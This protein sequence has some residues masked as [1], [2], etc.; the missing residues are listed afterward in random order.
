MHD[1]GGRPFSFL[2][3]IHLKNMVGGELWFPDALQGA[4]W[5][6]KMANRLL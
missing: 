1:D 6:Y 3:F 2:Q 4:L 5:F